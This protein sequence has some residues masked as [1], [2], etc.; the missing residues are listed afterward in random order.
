MEGTVFEQY[1]REL[2]L[3]KGYKV[4]LTSAS[5]DY[6]ADLILEKDNKKIVVQAKRYSK[7]VGIK[8]VQEVHS[9]LTYYKA[10]EAWVVTNNDFTPAA[11]KLAHSNNVK[12]INRQQLIELSLSLKNVSKQPK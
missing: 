4:T 8:A 5:G 10:K 9:A 11:V 7:P 6:G 1:L 12:L 3:K 2:Y